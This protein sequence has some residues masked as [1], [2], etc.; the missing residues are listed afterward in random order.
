MSMLH[1][2]KDMSEFEQQE[3]LGADP[4]TVVYDQIYP[5]IEKMYREK[6][7]M[8]HILLGVD[9]KNGN[10]VS[11]DAFRAPQ[12]ELVASMIQAV[13]NDYLVVAHIL[14][15]W[16]ATDNSVR[17]S[18]HPSR[19]DAVALIFYAQDCVAVANCVVD[20]AKRDIIRG[21]LTFSD[22]VAGTMAAPIPPRM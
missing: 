5:V 10:V 20:P 9:M 6:G 14:E 13:Q 11:I 2:A 3:A 22:G 8:D 17:P 19:K 1:R 15:C 12:K 18:E 4:F 21:E 7:V 16:I